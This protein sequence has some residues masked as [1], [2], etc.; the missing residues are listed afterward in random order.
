M[1]KN[2]SSA[3]RVHLLTLVPKDN[4]LPHEVYSFDL[5]ATSHI[6]TCL[7]NEKYVE[8]STVSLQDASVAKAYES[9]GLIQMCICM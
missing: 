2:A 4:A 7:E 5:G 3:I 8:V 6:D 9:D 1:R